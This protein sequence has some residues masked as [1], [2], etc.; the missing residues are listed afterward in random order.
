MKSIFPAVLVLATVASPALAQ[1][2]PADA[3]AKDNHMMASG[4]HMMPAMTK[5][6][7]AKLARCQKMTPAKAQKNAACAKLMA[8]HSNSHM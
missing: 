8:M 4:D 1:S 6:Q 2:A 7:M 3:M 5:P